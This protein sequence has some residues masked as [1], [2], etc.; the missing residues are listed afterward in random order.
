[1]KDIL[2]IPLL[3]I[4]FLGSCQQKQVGIP[5]PDEFKY[6]NTFTREGY[7]KDSLE[8]NE[9]IERMINKKEGPYYVKEHDSLTEVFIDTILYSPH[10]NRIATFVITKNSNDKLL[11]PGNPN[12]YHYNAHCFIA[13]RKVSGEEWNLKWFRRLNFTRHETYNY[14]SEKIRYRYFNN[15]AQLKGANGESQYKYNFDD[16]RF[17]DGPIWDKETVNNPTI[18]ESGDKK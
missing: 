10:N 5:T 18:F 4:G 6:I 8:I 12:E 3:L 17:W 15:L 1:M 14:V 13:D 2:F 11:S 7:L 9:K 16:I